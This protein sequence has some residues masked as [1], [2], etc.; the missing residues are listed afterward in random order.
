M[1][2]QSNYGLLR[3]FAKGWLSDNISAISSSG[4]N[5]AG[6]TVNLVA[7]GDLS[8]AS[9]DAS[10]KFSDCTSFLGKPSPIEFAG[11][12]SEAS[13]FVAGAAAL[14]IQ[15]YKKTHGGHLPSPAVVKQILLSTAS[16]HACD[17]SPRR[18]WSSRP[19]PCRR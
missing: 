14:V 17:H 7:P 3:Y 5:E 16:G 8:W 19:R 10:A 1:Y 2:A 6:G 18:S 12:T 4:Y 13:P 15:A 9:C 11:G